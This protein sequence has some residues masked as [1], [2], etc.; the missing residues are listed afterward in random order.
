MAAV[1]VANAGASGANKVSIGM[2]IKREEGSSLPPALFLMQ[3]KS[4]L[5]L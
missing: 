3:K 2:K 1:A 4:A 5:M